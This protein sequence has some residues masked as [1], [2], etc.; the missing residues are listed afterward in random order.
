[1]LCAQGHLAGWGCP[2]R[3]RPVLTSR[4]LVPQRDF[5]L[6]GGIRDSS[7]VPNDGKEEPPAMHR[8]EHVAPHECAPPSTPSKL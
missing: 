1:M 7:H 5:S 4:D 3:A 6:V 8:S 2:D